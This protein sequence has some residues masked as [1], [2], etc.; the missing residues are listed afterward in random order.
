MLV[1]VTKASKRD[2]RVDDR[3]KDRPNAVALLEVFDHPLLAG[4][5]RF[6]ARGR[7]SLALEQLESVVRRVENSSPEAAPRRHVHR[8]VEQKL[9]DAR[10]LRNRAIW[11]AC[12]HY[13]ERNH[14]PPRPRR[15]LVQVDR[16]PARQQDDLG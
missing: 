8:L 1:I 6:L 5:K 16:S 15:H 3:R 13:R 11:L 7:P 9:A 2:D 4:L 10:L 14:D 12:P